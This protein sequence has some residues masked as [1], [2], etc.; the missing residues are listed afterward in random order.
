MG[1]PREIRAIADAVPGDEPVPLSDTLSGSSS[2]LLATVTVPVRTPVAVGAKLTLM[3]QLA[4]AAS[5]LAHVLV[6]MKLP[7]VE[8][9]I[10]M[11]APLPVLLNEMGRAVLVVPVGWLEN[12]SDSG[13]TIAKGCPG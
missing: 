13:F 12:V 1:T 4:P 7:V 11:R 2:S 6:S 3:V 5:S 10:L 8:M 9:T